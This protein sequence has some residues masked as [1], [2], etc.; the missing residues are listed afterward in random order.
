M[1]AVVMA[2]GEG[3]RLRPV[4]VNVPKP[5]VPIANVPIIEHIF[6]LLKRHGVTD[7]IATL[8][9]LADEIQSYFGDGSDL[10]IH[11]EYTIEGSPLGT[12]GSVRRAQALLQDETFLIISGDSLTDCDLGKAI[13]FHKAHGGIATLVLSRV[14]NP[15]DFGVV[16]TDDK[17][18][19]ERFLEKPGWSEVFSDT[20]NTGLYVLEPAIFNHINPEENVDW[21]ADIFPKLLEQG[22]PL[23]GYVMEEYWCDVGSLSQ[24]REAQEDI[25]S[26]RVDLPIPGSEAPSDDGKFIGP[27]CKIDEA[28]ILVPPVCIGRNCRIKKGAR[29]GPYTV[30]GDNVFVEEGALVERSVIWDNAYIGANT[31]IHSAILCS[32]ATVKKDSVVRE[33]A[34]IGDRSVVDAGCTIRPRVKI[35]P[36]KVVE[37]GSTVTMSMV[38]GNRWRGNLFRELGVAGLSNIEITPDF[39]CRLAAAFGSTFPNGTKIVT[40]RD[41]TRSSRMIKRAVIA[42]LLSSGCDVLDLR[43]TALPVARHYIKVSGAGGAIH[44][45]KL[46][47]NAR[48]TLIEMMDERGAYISRSLER[49]VE[50]AFYR[51]DYRRADPDELG[52][53][54]FA[55]RAAEG[56]QADF[57]RLLHVRDSGRRFRIACDYGYSAIAT[58]LPA[59]LAQLGVEPIAL[60]GLNDAKRSPR[61]EEQIAHHIAHLRNIVETLGYDIGVLFLDDGER[62]VLVDNKGEVLDGPKLLAV[63]C[64]I[65]ARTKPEAKIVLSITAPSRLEEI[66]RSVGCTVIRTKADTHSL[67]TM[68]VDSAADLAGDD[69]GGFAFPA[70][71]IGFDAPFAFAKLVTMLQQTGLSLSEIASEVPSFQL[72]Y[73]AVRVPWETKGAVMRILA[74]EGR[75]GNRLELLDG[76][77]IHADDSWVLVLPDALE[78]IVHVYAE[79]ENVDHSRDLA[80]GYARRIDELQTSITR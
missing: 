79:S 44:V 20:V 4:T 55:S 50:T 19:I 21:S 10:G 2:G 41:S 72:A 26:G 45:R 15:L 61:S 60:N 29:V 5:L 46:P 53:I 3:S 80:T 43:S 67:L 65:V 25:L 16:V 42:A 17:G 27:S 57:H 63:Y 13:A 33:D 49:K 59:L 24:Y 12:A 39:A 7:V 18:R 74:E 30:I 8:H 51:E 37:R 76:V 36:D 62:L 71:Q 52:T 38:W 1:K 11:L 54:E 70:M 66:L 22:V 32:R 14:P 28:A 68:A 31:G 73:E 58:Y 56:Y 48:V 47:G 78:P 69:R 9:Y 64:T 35:W 6:T 77:K 40:S 34:V 75:D 23:F